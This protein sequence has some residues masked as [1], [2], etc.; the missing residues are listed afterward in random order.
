MNKYLLSRSDK[1]PLCRTKASCG[2][3][4]GANIFA[5]LPSYTPFEK[6]GAHGIPPP[7]RVGSTL[8]RPLQDSCASR[9]PSGSA[10]GLGKARRAA[11]HRPCPSASGTLSSPPVWGRFG[12]RARYKAALSVPLQGT[13]KKE[14]GEASTAPEMGRHMAERSPHA[15][16]TARAGGVTNRQPQG[17]E[18]GGCHQHWTTTTGSN[19]HRIS[20]MPQ[21]TRGGEGIKKKAMAVCKQ[22]RARCCTTGDVGKQRDPDGGGRR[23]PAPASSCCWSG[24]KNKQISAARISN[25]PA[26]LPPRAAS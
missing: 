17:Y 7:C 4:W 5:V 6:P 22:R 16:L 18:P 3:C 10:Q 23:G 2:A 15:P 24:D 25:P 13:I 26:A 9:C 14:R 1:A 11:R 8:D 12:S 20:E 21:E 19:A